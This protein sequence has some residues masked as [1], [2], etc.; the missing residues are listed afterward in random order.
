M[1]YR[2]VLTVTVFAALFS[3]ENPITSTG[4]QPDYF[5]EN[6]EANKMNIFGVLRPN[7][8]DNKA[9]S[10][11]FI[12]TTHPFNSTWD[13]TS[14]SD[15]EVVLYKSESNQ[16][17]DSLYFHYSEGDSANQPAYRPTTNFQALAGAT[18]RLVCQK[19]GYPQLTGQTTVPHVPSLLT[20]VSTMP[21][22]RCEFIIQHDSLAAMYDIHIFTPEQQY[23][24]RVLAPVSGDLSVSF[25]LPENTATEGLLLVYAYDR[26]LSEYMTANLSIKPQT[27]QSSF[28]T[29]EG[30]YGVFGALNFLGVGIRFE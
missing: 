15:A 17:T 18:Y 19:S 28:S 24:H 4:P 29:V 30:G 3:C 10:F 23:T 1:R 25:S 5:D 27:Y 16:L 9:D 6:S 20:D 26:N 7:Q 8:N 12:E 2:F 21:Q 14:I 22:K 11:V 13:S